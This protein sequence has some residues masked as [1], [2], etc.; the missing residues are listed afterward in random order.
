MPIMKKNV[1]LAIAL[2]IHLLTFSQTK[3]SV[4]CYT[5]SSPVKI[6]GILSE[7]CYQQ[8]QPAKD[9]VQLQPFNGKPSYQ[10]SEVYFFYDQDAIYVGAMLYDSAPDSIYN[11]LSERDNIGRS[12]YFGVYFDPY[13]EGQLAFGFFITPAGVQVDIKA[14]KTSYDYEDD[15]WDAVWESKTSI[16]DKGWVVEMRIPY[17]ALR[18]PL[19]EV[20]TWG[21]NM[22]RNIRRYNSNNSWS[23][24]DRNMDGFIHQQGQLTGIKN[25]KPPVRLAFSPYLS[26]YVE[27]DDEDDKTTTIYRGGL[28][29]K[30]GINESYTLD[31]MLIPD[32]GQIQSDDK[33]L[34]LSP[35]EL[36]YDE[37][38]QFFTEGVEL[39]NR[40]EIFYSRRI[41]ASPKFS[42]EAED[43]LL[44]NE[45]IS[46]MP[47][48]TQLVNA[49]KISGRNKKG[50]AVGFL[51]A[52]TMNSYATIED[53][54][55]ESSRK[56]KVQP[57]TNYNVTVIDQSLKNNSYI[58]FINTNMTVANHPFMANVTATEF[59]FRDKQKKYALSGQGGVSYRGEEDKET[60]WFTEVELEKNQGKWQYGV[61]QTAISDK[62]NPNDMGYLQR[63]N[64]FDTELY[65]V[66][67]LV[68]P[69]GIFRSMYTQL[70]ADNNRVMQ[71]WASY[72]TQVGV[73]N[74]ATFMN[75]YGYEISVYYMSDEH[76]YNEPR[77]DN[78]YFYK[79]PGYNYNLYAHTDW[80]KRLNAYVYFGQYGRPKRDQGGSWYGM[81]VSCQFGQRLEL[82]M[83]FN[84]EDE[85]N[86]YGYVDKNEAEDSIYFS[87]RNIGTIENIIELS[88]IFNNKLSLTFR[89]RHYWSG[90]ENFDFYLLQEDGHLKPESSY[91]EN[92]DDNYNAFNIDMVLRWVF[93]PG[94]EL[95]LGWKNA[96]YSDQE[97]THEDY[98]R[99]MKIVWNSPQINTFSLK[100]LYYIDYNSLK[101]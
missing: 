93:A 35:Y 53:T 16:N 26:T 4:E 19:K 47:S 65:G 43:D 18:F 48:E 27:H 56:I 100:A 89:G 87:R 20:H 85:I 66:Y 74:E 92:H 88:Y 81:G 9:F 75:N 60:G 8:A 83:E 13:N 31:M 11:Y 90:V 34:N 23:F 101:R 15:S 12:D 55:R 40:A 29:L 52:M 73:Y 28:D 78:R 91:A 2:A 1:L 57:F 98:N 49:T 5:L 30:Y 79:P 61:S 39:F 64:R 62:Y 77:V 10:P 41:G 3:K 72:N 80:N 94:S 36:Y 70:W 42:S 82:D 32:F 71:P 24:I 25:I 33:Q 54:M 97:D 51:N 50:F 46:E 17:S 45:E 6:D 58:S 69:F 37:R 67:Q 63:N 22:F 21:L 68:D 96:V 95:T 59:Q 76:N 86:D 99:N 44:D 84:Y 7:P 38:R 14:I